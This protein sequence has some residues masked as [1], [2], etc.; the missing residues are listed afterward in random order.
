[1]A[2]SWKGYAYAAQMSYYTSI[3]GWWPCPTNGREQSP[4]VGVVSLN[5]TNWTDA[6]NTMFQME[7]IGVSFPR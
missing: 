3:L 2:N 4:E 5:R 6:Y 1:M 7:C